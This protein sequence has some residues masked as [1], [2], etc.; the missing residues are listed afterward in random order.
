[1]PLPVPWFPLLPLL[2]PVRGGVVG[3]QT[4]P[5]SSR[6]GGP[7]PASRRTALAGLPGSQRNRPRLIHAA[8]GAPAGCH[9]ATGAFEETPPAPLP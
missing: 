3:R 1:M 5:T 4:P 8:R 2:P 9:A 7:P 6:P